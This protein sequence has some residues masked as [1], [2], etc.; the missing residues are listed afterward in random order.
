MSDYSYRW[1]RR[2]S[3]VDCYVCRGDITEVSHT[4]G[5]NDHVQAGE[6]CAY[7]GLDE[8]PWTELFKIDRSQWNGAGS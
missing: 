1:E 4:A 5:G 3:M 6:C 8:I 7:T 2:P